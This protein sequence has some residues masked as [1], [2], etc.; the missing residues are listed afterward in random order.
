MVRDSLEKKTQ[1]WKDRDRA[2]IEPA[3]QM[4]HYLDIVRINRILAD[5]PILKLLDYTKDLEFVLLTCTF[6]ISRS[7]ELATA[8]FRDLLEI[9]SHGGTG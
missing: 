3:M 7:K 2:D 6:D 4:E 1:K 5:F 8:K 9:S